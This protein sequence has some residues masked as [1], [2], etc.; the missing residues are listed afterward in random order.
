MQK[1]PEEMKG[2][3]KT[4]LEAQA[5]FELQNLARKIEVFGSAASV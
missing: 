2:M 3:W 4:L 5:V 1:Q